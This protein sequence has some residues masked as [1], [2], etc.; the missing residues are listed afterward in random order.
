MDMNPSEWDF[1]TLRIRARLTKKECSKL[2]GKSI[3]TIER[4]EQSKPPLIAIRALEFR[5]GTAPGWINFTFTYRTVTNPLGHTLSCS[6]IEQFDYLMQLKQ[7][8]G[9]A[10]AWR[11]ANR[12]EQKK[13]DVIYLD[14][15]RHKLRG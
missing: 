10:E 11:E 9:H 7:E 3:K 2:L 6:Q 1:K 13:C 4:W 12:K 14:D 5:A 15:Y 8:I